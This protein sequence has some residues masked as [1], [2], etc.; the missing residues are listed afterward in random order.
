MVKGVYYI[1]L[2]RPRHRYLYSWMYIS[3]TSQFN[4]HIWL[5]IH[6]TGW[7]VRLPDEWKCQVGMTLSYPS[8]W[9]ALEIPKLIPLLNIMKLTLLTLVIS[10]KYPLSSFRSTCRPHSTRPLTLR[11][12]V[13]ILSGYMSLSLGNLSTLKS[14][15]LNLRSS[16]TTRDKRNGVRYFLCSLALTNDW[17]L[18]RLY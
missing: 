14:S 6:S 8:N 2:N 7:T 10:W 18:S 5:L 4:S 11:R 3:F 15:T 1:Y 13:R 17:L 16:N 12:R 9:V